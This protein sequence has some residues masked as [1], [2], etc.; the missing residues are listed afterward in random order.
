MQ[1]GYLL[2]FGDALRNSGII[3]T[4]NGD[5]RLNHSA[6]LCLREKRKPLPIEY[7]SSNF[8]HDYRSIGVRSPRLRVP[9]SPS[10]SN[11]PSPIV[12]QIHST[13]LEQSFSSGPLVQA[14]K[15]YPTR[16]PRLFPSSTRRPISSSRRGP[17]A[18]RIRGDA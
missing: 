15:S 2:N 16:N 14:L 8:E 18:A 12:T 6:P 13:G 5:P 3:P 4:I 17:L 10:L 9:A 7:H 11:S 1:L